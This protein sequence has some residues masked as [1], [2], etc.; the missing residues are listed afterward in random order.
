L[1]AKSQAFIVFDGRGRIQ[2]GE[3]QG[4]LVVTRED[5]PAEYLMQLREKEIDFI[6]AGR[7]DR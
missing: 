3:T 2:W 1:A 5:S 7:G 4:L 6:Q